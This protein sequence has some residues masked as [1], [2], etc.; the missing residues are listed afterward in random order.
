[1]RSRYAPCL[2]GEKSPLATFSTCFFSIAVAAWTFVSAS[3]AALQPGERLTDSRLNPLTDLNGYFPL[4]VPK[5]PEEWSA[6]SEQV[7]NRILVSQ[8][9]LPLPAKSP[10]EAVVHGRTAFD[11]YTVEK[12][13]FQSFPGFFVTGNLYRPA[14]G[15]GPFPGVLCPH[16][17]WA[18][19]RFM[20]NA[21]IRQEIAQG[22]ERF[23]QGGRSPLQA[24]CVQLARIGCVV[25]HYDMIGYADS[26][27]ISYELAHRFARQRPEMNRP[28]G[29]GLF[30]PQAES[31]LQSVMGLQSWNSIRALDFLETLPYVDSERLGITGASGGG[32]QTFMLAAIDER[33]ATAF[34]AVM[35]STAMQG[36]CTCEN[37]SLLRIG[38]G[39]VEFAALFA[40][41]PL[42]LSGANDW[43]VEMPQ[44]GFP[45]LQAL[46]RMLGQENHVT[47]KALNHFGHN[48]N[49]VSRTAMYH[50]FN[51]HLQ[52][53]QEEPILERDYVFQSR[54]Q[55]TVWN[56]THPKPQGGE[57]FERQLLG[58]WHRDT[59]EKLRALATDPERF[60]AA[61]RPAQHVVAG[62]NL[63]E[64]GDL[65]WDLRRK[66]ERQGYLEMTG[67]LH[68]RTWN[69]SL[70]VTFLYPDSWNRVTAIWL[71]PDGKAGLYDEH[72]EVH[73]TVRRLLDRGVSV[74]GPDL[75]YQGEFLTGDQP[76]TQ[77][78]RVSQTSREAAAYTHGY[79]HAVFAQRVHDVLSVVEFVR[80]NPRESERIVLIGLEGAGHWA[81]VARSLDDDA[82]HR[83]VIDTAGFRFG[84][85]ESIRD[86]DFLPGGARYLDLPGFLVAGPTQPLWLAGEPEETQ[87]LLRR[88]YAGRTDRLNFREPDLVDWILE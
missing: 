42:G 9:L 78:R 22:A 45:E 50:W 6:R 60:V 33:L 25:F 31:Q 63:T 23:E 34:P 2:P 8:G 11:G 82:I 37:A 73:R 68:N 26:E 28:E 15:D 74:A 75:I 27:Q 14:V 51:R 35:V 49:S 81:A 19:G 55:L 53:G 54:A 43:T 69:E 76:L 4:E 30:S 56:E 13:Y 87:R 32:T 44:K 84:A 39:N 61:V 40:P 1:M 85:V 62:R 41:R 3:P 86:P 47:L 79:N 58:H 12:V 52:L 83:C 67:L 80:S 66:T 20:D 36:G 70:P 24:R 21:R 16:G 48:Y 57:E 29:W 88:R 17:H 18:A 71:S 7:R 77:T 65:E 46:Y 38:T 5:S 10:L 59:Q 64:A 72:D